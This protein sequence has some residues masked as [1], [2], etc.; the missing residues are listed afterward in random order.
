MSEIKVI[1]K[2]S[3][4][5][6]NDIH[7]SL[8][9]AH[10]SNRQKGIYM[11]TSYLSGDELLERI[12]AKSRGNYD[13][14]VALDGMQV[15]GTAAICYVKNDNWYANKLAWGGGI[16]CMVRLSQNIKEKGYLAS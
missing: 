13:V 16:C 8:W 7:N 14:F 15:V 1:I 10:E 12:E 2:P 5:T 4:I 11:K 6:W 9:A 3:C